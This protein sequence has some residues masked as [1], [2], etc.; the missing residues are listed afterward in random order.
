MEKIYKLTQ[1]EIISILASTFNTK[2]DNVDLIIQDVNE[3]YGPMEHTEHRIK[4]IISKP[5][6]I[7]EEL[8]HF[9]FK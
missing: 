9:D 5:V 6:I 3:G 7:D 1:Q 8:T 2:Y 4:A